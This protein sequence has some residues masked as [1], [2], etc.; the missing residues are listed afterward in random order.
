MAVV[1]EWFR[2]FRIPVALGVLAGAVLLVGSAEGESGE[3][4]TPYC[5]EWTVSGV[6]EHRFTTD[7]NDPCYTATPNARHTADSAKYCH[8]YH[9][10]C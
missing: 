10:D 6:T 1:K 5:R 9:G 2:A 8:T 7:A 3:G 4:E